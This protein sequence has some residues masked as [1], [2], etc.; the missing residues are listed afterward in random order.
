[1]KCVLQKK[2]EFRD[3]V[4]TASDHIVQPCGVSNLVAYFTRNVKIFCLNFNKVLPSKIY[5]AVPQFNL[6]TFVEF[7][8]DNISSSA[9]EGATVSHFPGNDLTWWNPQNLW[10]YSS[11]VLIIITDGL[12]WGSFRPSND[13][14]GCLVFLVGWDVSQKRKRFI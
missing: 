1:M 8:L 6:W 11:S 4:C 3:I 2:K 13:C 14:N 12:N 5:L 7:Y 9:A 10:N